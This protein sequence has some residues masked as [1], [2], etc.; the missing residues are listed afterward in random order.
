[1]QTRSNITTR[2]E[3]CKQGNLEAPHSGIIQNW[4][5]RILV[6]NCRQD[7]RSETL[8]VDN[9]QVLKEEIHLIMSEH[10]IVQTEVNLNYTI[11]ETKKECR[12]LAFATSKE[13]SEELSVQVELLQVSA[14]VST[15]PQHVQRGKLF[16]ETRFFVSNL[17]LEEGSKCFE[18]EKSYG[19]VL[20]QQFALQ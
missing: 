13:T 1:M 14:E 4:S 6:E 9:K 3:S 15:V 18:L 16:R 7:F 5:K 2:R 8:L 17:L 11:T 12:S 20:E 10:S 19:F